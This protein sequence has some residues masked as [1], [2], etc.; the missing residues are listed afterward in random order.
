VGS[1][2]PPDACRD[3]PLRAA[4]FPKTG[5]PPTA[6]GQMLQNLAKTAENYILVCL[7]QKTVFREADLFLFIW[8]MLFIES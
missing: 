2:N 5:G 7:K 6:S 4:C 8:L 3:A 1:F